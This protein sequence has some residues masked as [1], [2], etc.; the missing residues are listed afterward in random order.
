MTVN[1]IFKAAFVGKTIRVRHERSETTFFEVK[2]VKIDLDDTLVFYPAKGAP[3]TFG[4]LHSLEFIQGPVASRSE[5]EKAEKTEKA[6]KKKERQDE[7][8]SPLSRTG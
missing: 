1:D 7:H 2:D 4:P 8:S 6:E 5:P 3:R